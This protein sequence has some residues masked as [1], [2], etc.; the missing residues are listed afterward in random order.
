MFNIIVDRQKEY[1]GIQKPNKTKIEGATIGIVNIYET[2][3]RF[4]PNG[5]EESLL[6]CYSLENAGA[7]TD[8]A[9]QDKRIIAREYNIEW[10][11]TGVCVPKKYKGQGLLLSCDSVLPSFRRRR[12]LIHI[13]NY[14]QDSEGCLLFGKVDNKN[15]TIGKS[16]IAIE[17]FYDFVKARGTEN[18]RLIVR[19]II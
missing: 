10:T 14:P 5:S 1:E 17:E 9:G 7:S 2:E 11:A 19:E 13:G 15:G 6:Q 16:T 4:Y 3:G 18:F 8:I 12:I